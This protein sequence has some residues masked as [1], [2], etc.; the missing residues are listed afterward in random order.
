[1]R[2]Q[3]LVGRLGQVNRV[4]WKLATMIV[5]VLSTPSLAPGPEGIT[6]SFV[7]FVSWIVRKFQSPQTKPRSYRFSWKEAIAMY[8]V[9]RL[10]TAVIALV[11]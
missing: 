3:L 2:A 5:N 10:A 1:M 11:V 6:H 8:I 4:G 9:Y 7:P